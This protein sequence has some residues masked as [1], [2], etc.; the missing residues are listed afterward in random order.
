MES[1]IKAKETET[2]AHKA[3]S[4]GEF[5]TLYYYKGSTCG[6]KLEDKDKHI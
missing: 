6:S 3:N 1:K 2:R 4:Q 5:Y